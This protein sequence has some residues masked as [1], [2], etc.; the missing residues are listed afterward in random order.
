M[1]PVT[2]KRSDVFCDANQER[3]KKTRESTC[4][5]SVTWHWGCFCLRL[6]PSPAKYCY[7]DHRDTPFY[8][9]K[10]YSYVW[11]AR[12]LAR[13]LWE[14]ILVT[15]R[16]S[17]TLK[18]PCRT[19]RN[20]QVRLSWL[21]RSCDK[22]LLSPNFSEWYC[23]FSWVVGYPTATEFWRLRHLN[24]SSRP[25]PQIWFPLQITYDRH[26]CL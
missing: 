15:R 21:A 18:P 17:R 10:C 13:K 9:L 22:A 23:I 16:K 20:S 2:V 5:E 14:E 19:L 26:L 24:K 6:L 12:V 4:S 11:C 7:I 25:R 8:V 3:L 1:G